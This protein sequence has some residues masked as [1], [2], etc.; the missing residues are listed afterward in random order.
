MKS[1]EAIL[2]SITMILIIIIGLVLF[3]SYV[4]KSISNIDRQE[5]YEQIYSEYDKEDN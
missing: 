3:F 5:D 1:K 2:I 4:G